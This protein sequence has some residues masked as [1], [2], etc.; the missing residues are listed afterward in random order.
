[1]RFGLLSDIHGNYPALQAAMKELQKHNIEQLLVAGDIIGYY[2]YV[3]EVINL[4][5]QYDCLAIKGNHENYFLDTLKTP[6]E[7]PKLYWLD[8]VESTISEI[9]REWLFSLNSEENF[10][11]D[12]SRIGLYHGS[13]WD[14]N[15]Y[16]YPDFQSFDRFAELEE[17][18]FIIGH[19][20]IPLVK[21][22]GRKMIINP[23]SCGQPRDY[24]PGA[25]FGILDTESAR[26]TLY[27]AEYDILTLLD[28]LRTSGYP[29][30][31]LDILVRRK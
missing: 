5:R 9:S 30:P 18:I 24:L 3:N 26:T 25:C 10:M 8:H 15:E 13:P 1:M 4:L 20:H 21:Q 6:D 14:V 23:G 2:P 29:Q 28:E 17:D 31:L 16:V 11:I 19:T 12:G 27:R 22:I 7:K